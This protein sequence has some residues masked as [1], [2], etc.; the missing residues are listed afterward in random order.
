MKIALFCQCSLRCVEYSQLRTAKTGKQTNKRTEAQKQRTLIKLLDMYGTE[1][2][3]LHE[4]LGSPP[5]PPPQSSLPLPLVFFGEVR[6]AHLFSFLCCVVF[7][8]C[9]VSLYP[10]S[11]SNAAS[12]QELSILYCP[13]VFRSNLIV[14]CTF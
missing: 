14:L 13:H 11:C 8:F 1:L 3:T 7:L 2:L 6:V 12:S 5:P 10:V 4:H 9:V